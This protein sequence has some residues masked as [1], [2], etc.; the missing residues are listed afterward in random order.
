[1]TFV[2]NSVPV[3]MNIWLARYVW[4][5]SNYYNHIISKYSTGKLILIFNS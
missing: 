3:K 1:M 4:Q 5:L 2:P